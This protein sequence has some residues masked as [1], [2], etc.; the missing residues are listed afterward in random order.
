MVAV[1]NGNNIH[2]FN[3]I[4]GHIELTL[5]GHTDVSISVIKLFII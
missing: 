1:T 4:K 3:K 5:K 2:I